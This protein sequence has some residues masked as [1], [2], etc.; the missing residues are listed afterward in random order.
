[1]RPYSVESGSGRL[2]YIPETKRGSC[3]SSAHSGHIVDRVL[4]VGKAKGSFFA[5]C[6]VWLHLKQ[7]PGGMH[8]CLA[9]LEVGGGSLR[10]ATKSW[11]FRW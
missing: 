9:H 11:A 4:V 3:P 2:T 5:Q 6:L 7:T 8:C 10:V 1:M